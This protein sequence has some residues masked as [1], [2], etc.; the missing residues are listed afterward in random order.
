M[1][2]ILGSNV[3]MIL[4]SFPPAQSRLVSATK[5]GQNIVHPPDTAHA[6][7]GCEREDGVWFA[8]PSACVALAE[9]LRRARVRNGHSRAPRGVVD[10]LLVYT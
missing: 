2:L 10:T 3:L 6:P 1:E 8:T 9:P 7:M 5:K 4:V